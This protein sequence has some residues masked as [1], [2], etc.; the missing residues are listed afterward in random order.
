MWNSLSGLFAFSERSRGCRHDTRTGEAT[1]ELNL[2]RKGSFNGDT[3][4][5]FYNWV[6]A[7]DLTELQHMWIQ[8]QKEGSAVLSAV[9]APNSGQTHSESLCW[10]NGRQRTDLLVWYWAKNCVKMCDHVPI[11]INVIWITL[12]YTYDTEWAKI[13][14]G[15]L[16]SIYYVWQCRGWTVCE[17]SATYISLW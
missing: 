13:H 8:W 4:V 17:N 14:T 9:K 15:Q 1:C 16:Y 5:T 7:I 12:R 6:T 11:Q 10:S 3:R 2:Y